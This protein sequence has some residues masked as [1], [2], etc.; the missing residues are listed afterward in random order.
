MAGDG[1]RSGDEVDTGFDPDAD[2]VA[3]E[4][5]PVGVAV[6]PCETALNTSDVAG[7]APK[8]E[9]RSLVE[10]TELLITSD[11][12][13]VVLPKII[14]EPKKTRRKQLYFRF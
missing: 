11:E 5:A 12:G 3:G 4:S 10:G 7:F 1:W 13:I 8:I 9:P 14:E 6:P 2:A